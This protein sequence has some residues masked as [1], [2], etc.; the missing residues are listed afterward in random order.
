MSELLREQ[1]MQLNRLYKE[2]NERYYET[3][4]QLGISSSALMILYGLCHAGR[5]CTQKELCDTWYLKKQ[6]LH[7]ALNH[8]LKSGDICVHP[9]SEN[10]RMKLLMLTEKGQA[11]CEKSAI[12]FLQAEEQA[13]ARLTPEE[14]RALLELTRKHTRYFR[15]CSEILINTI[16]T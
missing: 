6:T 3:A 12:P 8:L 7:S 15:E 5:P 14:R 4:A 1:L 9:S 13:F 11:L 16:H 2:G 10:S